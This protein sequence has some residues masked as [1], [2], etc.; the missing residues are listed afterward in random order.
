MEQEFIDVET[1][2]RS[3]RTQFTQL[4]AWLKKQEGCRPILVEKTDRLYR[5]L[6]AWVELDGLDLETLLVKE[7]VILSDDSRSY[8]KF[9]HGIKVLI[10]KNYFENLSEKT[11]MGMLEKP[12]QGIWPG[13]APIGYLNV[14][15]PDGKRIIALDHETAPLVTRLF[16]TYAQGDISVQAQAKQAAGWGCAV[17]GPACPSPWRP[18]TTPR[19]TCSTP[20]SSS[21]TTGSTRPATP[22]W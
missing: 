2:K 13:P 16:E 3:G 12:E 7:N 10:A 15:H 21:G 19:P 20:G 1:A 11:R 17:S 6:K 8:E 9:M 14:S 5:N 4:L 18:S 22:R